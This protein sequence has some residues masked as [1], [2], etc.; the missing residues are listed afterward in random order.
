[1]FIILFQYRLHKYEQLEIQIQQF[2][3]YTSY[4][5]QI[6]QFPETSMSFSQHINTT[7]SVNNKYQPY[8]D[9]GR[10]LTTIPSTGSVNEPFA[11]LIVQTLAEMAA[12]ANKFTGSGVI[13]IDNTIIT[14][15]LQSRCLIM[16][17]LGL[18]KQTQTEEEECERSEMNIDTKI[19][20]TVEGK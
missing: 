12:S 18:L 10:F 15:I 1:M 19:G 11:L 5:S 14:V 20:A 2:V 7:G 16:Y 3:A 9:K 6:Y 4:V 17:V 13:L 8:E